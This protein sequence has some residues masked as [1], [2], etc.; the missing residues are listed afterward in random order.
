ME[1]AQSDVDDDGTIPVVCEREIEIK[2]HR[3]L[4]ILIIFDLLKANWDNHKLA[5]KKL[6]VDGPSHHSLKFLCLLGVIS[7]ISYVV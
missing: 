4:C 2:K 7:R 5:R 6:Q 3:S 1:A